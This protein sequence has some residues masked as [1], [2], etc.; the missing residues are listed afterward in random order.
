MQMQKITTLLVF[1]FMLMVNACSSPPSIEGFDSTKWKNDPNA[2]ESQREEFFEILISQKAQ[3][4]SLNYDSVIDLFG[5]PDERDLYERGQWF[6]YYYF[7]PGPACDSSLQRDEVPRIIFRF[8]AQGD[9]T[10]V[11]FRR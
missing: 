11:T 5:K 9:V 3:L 8:S 2:C 10:E 7:T 1:L 6:Y 4:L